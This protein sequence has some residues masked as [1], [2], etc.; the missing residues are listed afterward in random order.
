MNSLDELWAD[1]MLGRRA[2]AELLE[3]VLVMEASEFE[4]LGREQAFVLAI[5]AAYG[6]GKT[7]FLTKLRQHLAEK[8]PVAI[9]DAWV[10]DASDEP[11][12]AIMSAINDALE[13]YLESGAK[14]KA[15][16][17]GATA[18]ALPIIG[19][20]AI[21]AG[22]T[23]L[24]KYAGDSIPDEIIALV[25]EKSKP[26]LEERVIDE[27]IGEAANSIS[28]LADKLGAEMLAGYK[29]RQQSKASFKRNMRA[30]VAGLKNDTE[31]LTKPLFVIIDELDRCRP[32][33]A[34][35]VLEEV[36]H[37]FDIPGVVFIIA[38]HGDQLE[39]SIAAV[40]GAKFE[41]KSYLN[42]F[43]T[44]RYAL[45][46]LTMRELIASRI[47]ADELDKINWNY[48]GLAK[49]Q[50][51]VADRNLT[52]LIN[53][54]C[55]DYEVSPREFHSITDGLRMF[56]KTWKENISIELVFVLGLLLRSV[57]AIVGV[58]ALDMA[59][60][61]A[62]AIHGGW[63]ENG[64]TSMT[65]FKKLWQSYE[66]MKDVKIFELQTTDYRMTAGNFVV[67]IMDDE[68]NKRFANRVEPGAK[69]LIHTYPD[70]V[71]RFGRLLDI[72]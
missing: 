39:H 62:T 28:C 3:E 53:A 25:D 43:F 4:R 36:K 6:E 34:I 5:D 64:R 55:Y 40:Y 21:G 63:D 15:W 67:G 11:L 20:L 35:K 65:S 37:L 61:K 58:N 52:D 51:G 13:P 50:G 17:K 46:R 16:L 60:G 22:K 70:R 8:H 29:E 69:S 59:S 14:T 33:Y 68:R 12:L 18:A 26:S 42:R 32:D 7:F 57:R 72:Q 9:V 38:M 49:P 31:G 1:D 45:R 2:E 47:L 48:P 66:D 41:A 30:L 54:F 44:R 23:A 10:D 24:R 56:G 71:A 27:V 19:K